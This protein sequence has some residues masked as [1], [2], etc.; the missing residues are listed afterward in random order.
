MTTG[1]GKFDRGMQKGGKLDAGRDG[2][3]ENQKKQGEDGET[4]MDSTGTKLHSRLRK[5]LERHGMSLRCGNKLV[6]I[7]TYAL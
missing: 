3:L 6:S 7:L 1:E 4:L 5:I 2:F